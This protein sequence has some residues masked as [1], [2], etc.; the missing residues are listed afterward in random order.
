M[1]HT[2]DTAATAECLV[3]GIHDRIYLSRGDIRSGN[4]NHT[5]SFSRRSYRRETVFSITL[6]VNRPDLSDYKVSMPRRLRASST[7]ARS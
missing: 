2:I 1:D 4:G 5:N 7:S 6:S 3:R